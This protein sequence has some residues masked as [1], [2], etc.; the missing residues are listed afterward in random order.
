MA[1]SKLKNFA[2]NLLYTFRGN[3]GFIHIFSG[4]CHGSLAHTCTQLI[5]HIWGK[6]IKHTFNGSWKLMI[7]QLSTHLYTSDLDQPTHLFCHACRLSIINEQ[8]SSV[9]RLHTGIPGY[10]AANNIIRH[11][12][13]GS[14]RI[15]GNIGGH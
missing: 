10:K 1:G 4:F 5:V 15:A 2:P 3:D 6:Y 11:N 14:Y 8:N 13:F 9:V 7:D 12:N